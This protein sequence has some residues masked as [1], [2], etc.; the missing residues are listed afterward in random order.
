MKRLPVILIALS[1]FTVT[2]RSQDTDPLDVPIDP[3]SRLITYQEVVPESGTKDE[4]F[5][6]AVYWLNEFYKSPVEITKV[7]DQ[8]SGIIKG[9]HQFRVYYN[10][11]QGN[12]L[13]GGMVLYNFKIEL[14]E[15]R[16]RYTVDN[17]TLRQVSRFPVERW[18]NKAD[19]E[20]SDRWEGF[21]QQVDAFVK[22]EFAPTLKAKMKPEVKVKE[23]EW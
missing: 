7:R 19:P 20:Y 18:L 2:S 14:K 12:K 17:F 16:Y 22:E 8:A 10:D 5:N 6:R 9:Q 3:N 11:E 4:L 15:N 21:L 1:L 23:A 13:D